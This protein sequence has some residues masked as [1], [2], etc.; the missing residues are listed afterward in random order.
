M[1]YKLIISY[2]F[3]LISG[4]ILF[5]INVKVMVILVYLYNVGVGLKFI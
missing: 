5:F 4:K 2:Y 1:K 3:I